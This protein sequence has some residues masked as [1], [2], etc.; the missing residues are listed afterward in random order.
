MY[1]FGY[2]ETFAIPSDRSGMATICFAIFSHKA[3]QRTLPPS[4]LLFQSDAKSFVIFISAA[5]PVFFFFCQLLKI[6]IF[7]VR[8]ELLVNDIFKT[9]SIGDKNGP[10]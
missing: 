5:R 2:A 10:A 6:S 1:Y 7:S 3:R 4:D 9:S 8:T